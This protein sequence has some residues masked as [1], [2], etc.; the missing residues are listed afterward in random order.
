MLDL[1][2]WTL[3]PLGQ[4]RQVT[5]CFKV[6]FDE[7]SFYFIFPKS[8]RVISPRFLCLFRFVCSFSFFAS[9]C[10]TSCNLKEKVTFTLSVANILTSGMHFLSGWEKTLTQVSILISQ[11]WEIRQFFLHHCGWQ[12]IEICSWK[13]WKS[14]SNTSE[15]VRLECLLFRFHLW[16]SAGIFWGL[17]SDGCHT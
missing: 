1:R 3:T 13:A 5:C 10:L 15:K 2:K 8:F 14:H 9:H 4:V 16:T 17:N 7:S 6:V 11:L 12:R